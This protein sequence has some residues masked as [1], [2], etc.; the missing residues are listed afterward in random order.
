METIQLPSTLKT[1]EESAFYNSNIKNII[2]PNGLESIGDEA[3]G[4]CRELENVTIHETIKSIGKHAFVGSKWLDNRKNEEDREYRHF[5]V[6]GDLLWSY[7]N[8]FRTPDIEIPEGIK[9]IGD[10]AFYSSYINTIKIPEGVTSIGKSAFEESIRLIEV[11]IPKSITEIKGG[12]FDNCNEDLVIIV[13][14]NPKIAKLLK[15]EYG[16]K[17]KIITK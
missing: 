1:I 8:S 9:R 13:E 15:A 14:S 6:I 16:A 11:T 12:A 17:Y 4:D 2:L 5:Q 10:F 7:T 3:F